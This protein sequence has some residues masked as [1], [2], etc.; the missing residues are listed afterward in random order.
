MEENGAAS[1]VS[2]DEFAALEGKV[3]QTVELI[4]KERSAHAVTVGE[5]D[6]AQSEVAALRRQLQTQTETAS[7]TQQE[8]DALHRELE[9]R[10]QELQA[11]NGELEALHRERGTLKERVER[12][13]Q[14]MEELLESR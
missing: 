1:T 6:Q 5:R 2:A 3:L 8:L 4:K 11:R 7:G 10:T 9:A 14:T 13:L 12:M